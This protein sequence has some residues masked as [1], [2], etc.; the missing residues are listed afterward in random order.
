LAVLDLKYSAVVVAFLF[1]VCLGL[2]GYAGKGEGERQRW[3]A[4]CGREEGRV[5][6]GGTVDHRIVF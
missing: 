6:G 5:A 3:D 2:V 4:V 1:C